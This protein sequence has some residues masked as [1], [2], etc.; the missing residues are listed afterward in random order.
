[1]FLERPENPQELT[2]HQDEQAHTVP[3]PKGG[4]AARITNDRTAVTD[5]LTRPNDGTR[6]CDSGHNGAKLN[7]PWGGPS[8]VAGRPRWRRIWITGRRGRS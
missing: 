4:V 6:P 7:G 3:L 2:L 8:R 1:M 5:A